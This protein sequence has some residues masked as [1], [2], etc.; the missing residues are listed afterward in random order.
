MCVVEVTLGFSPG[1][2]LVPS[3]YTPP[4]FSFSIDTATVLSTDVD[5]DLT[6]ANGV[7]NCVTPSTGALV[8][9]TT[10][11]GGGTATL[12]SCEGGLAIGSWTQNTTAGGPDAN[13]GTSVLAG[14]WGAWTLAL[15]SGG[16]KAVAQLTI[17]PDEPL[18]VVDCAGDGA[19]GIK[20][21]GLL[22]FVG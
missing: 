18:T 2:G 8:R 20:T 9:T 3:I 19:T 7:Q 4:T 21:I 5:V 10:G 6:E 13:G 17:H 1:L 15:V 14:T 16:M 22:E 12:F 11:G